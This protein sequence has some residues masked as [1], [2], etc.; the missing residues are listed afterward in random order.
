MYAYFAHYRKQADADAG[1]LRSDLNQAKNELTLLSN[2]TRD[3]VAKPLI[4]DIVSDLLLC[5][6]NE[7]PH[8]I[9]DHTSVSSQ[10]KSTSHTHNIIAGSRIEATAHILS[11][12]TLSFK[13]KVNTLLTIHN[14]NNTNNL[15]LHLSIPELRSRIDKAKQAFIT[16]P[17]LKVT[18]PDEYTLIQAYDEIEAK[19]LLSMPLGT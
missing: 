19:V 4:K 11:F 17:D 9:A 6:T 7:H 12:D 18:M 10:V 14:N 15:P 13:S 5:I 2:C 1:S 8:P 16:F 3:I